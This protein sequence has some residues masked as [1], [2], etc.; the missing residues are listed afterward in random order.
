MKIA[1]AG[2]RARRADP[3][4]G[5]AARAEDPVGRTR[6]DVEALRSDRV[7]R[8]R[9][10]MRVGG[11]VALASVFEL[12]AH[13]SPPPPASSASAKRTASTPNTIITIR[14]R[15]RPGTRST[16]SADGESAIGVRPLHARPSTPKAASLELESICRPMRSNS[17]SACTHRA[18]QNPR[19][20]RTT[21]ATLHTTTSIQL[22]QTESSPLNIRATPSPGTRCSMRTRVNLTL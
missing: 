5:V 15:R 1:L 6:A 7:G 17:Y 2:P 12:F 19:P 8:A 14:P 11:E 21:R 4:L 16:R 13:S 10:P 18:P 22:C 20:N 3:H 9:E